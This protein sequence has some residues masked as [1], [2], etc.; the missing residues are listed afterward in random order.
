MG[1]WEE[2]GSLEATPRQRISVRLCCAGDSQ[3]YLT[4]DSI[5]DNRFLGVVMKRLPLI[6]IALIAFGAA[7]ALAADMPAKAPVYKAP[8][9]VATPTWTGCYL[10]GN[11]GYGWAK[12]QWSDGGVEFAS[13]TATGAIGG[14]QIGCDYQT[15]PWVYGIQGIFDWSGMKG[16][17]SKTTNPA[18]IDRSWISWFATLTGRMG[19]VVQPTTLLYIK[20]GA[21]WVRDKHEECCLPTAPPVPVDDGVANLTRSG[22][23]VGAGFE[24]L[25]QPN[26][27]F[28]VEYD[29]LDLGT[30]AVIFAPIGPTTGPFTH[31]IRQNVQTVLI[32]LN[33]RFGGGTVVAKY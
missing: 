23:T 20:G 19:Y 22:W 10:G 32:G 2:N 6:A 4:V 7:T 27:S 33:Y 25:F 12:K 28:F 15:G 3:S 14:G 5:V 13:H 29:Y 18:I 8:P 30:R 9:V 17:S 11:V 26:W 24:H 21:A 31:D 1:R 16:D